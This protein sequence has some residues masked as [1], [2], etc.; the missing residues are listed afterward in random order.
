MQKART[1]LYILIFLLNSPALMAQV[2]QAEWRYEGPRVGI[3]LSRL[4]TPYFQQAKRSGWEIQADIPVKGNFFPTFETGM[5]WFDDNRE[6]FR[7]RNNGAYARLGMD[8]NIMKFESL[9]DGDLV[10]VGARYGFSRFKHQADGISYTNYWGDLSTSVPERNMNAHWAELV[11]GMKGELMPNLFLGWSLRAKFPF[12]KTKDPN[13]EPY[14]IPGVG[15]TAGDVPFDFSFGLYYR[16]PIFKTKTLPKPIQMG[17]STH[18]E[19]EED[20]EN[21]QSQG[22]GNSSGGGMNL[23]NMRSGGM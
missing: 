6:N 16:F 23:R 22:F 12:A 2:K 15:K 17:G 7:Y 5:Q 3:D 8:M 9:S 13:M 14:I 21:G 20:Q 1:L 19:E 11:F 4:L 10:F 18:T